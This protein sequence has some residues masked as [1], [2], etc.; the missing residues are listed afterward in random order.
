MY[1]KIKGIT[2]IYDLDIGFIMRQAC[3]QDGMN[4]YNCL[5]GCD[6]LDIL[7]QLHKGQEET[8]EES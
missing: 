5:E 6:A 7:E 4:C 2:Y 1:I 3:Y 8:D